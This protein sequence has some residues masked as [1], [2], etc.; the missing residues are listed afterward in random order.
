MEPFKLFFE[1]FQ[2]LSKVLKQVPSQ[3]TSASGKTAYDDEKTIKI[4][5]TQ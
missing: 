5:A 1:M 4:I 2:I 3:Q